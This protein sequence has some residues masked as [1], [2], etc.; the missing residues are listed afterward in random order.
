LFEKK[1]NTR[2]VLIDGLSRADKSP[3]KLM[4]NC[5]IILTS[6]VPPEL[7][8]ELALAVTTSL[9]ALRLLRVFCTE[10]FRIPLAGKLDVCCFDK[11]GTLTRDDLNF[12]GVSGGGDDLTLNTTSKAIS[13]DALV[14]IGGCQSLSR[15]EGKASKEEKEKRKK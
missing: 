3:Y 2:Y 7:P 5:I 14:V 9:S 1:N 15:V 13:D 8:I 10:P 6:V 4:L 11:T 12:V